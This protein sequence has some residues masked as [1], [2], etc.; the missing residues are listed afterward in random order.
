ME[1]DKNLTWNKRFKEGDIVEI[2][3]DKH[4][5]FYIDKK[6]IYSLVS[7]ARNSYFPLSN[8]ENRFSSK[9]S[10]YEKLLNIFDFENSKNIQKILCGDDLQAISFIM[11]YL[12]NENDKKEKKV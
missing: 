10:Q 5:C 8:F 7:N 2:P 3:S 6:Q 1:K 9:S 11:D 4:W 12:R